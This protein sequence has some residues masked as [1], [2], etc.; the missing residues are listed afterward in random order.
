MNTKSIIGFVLSGLGLLGLLAWSFPQVK[1]LIPLP[2]IATDT[3]LLTA[4]TVL[5]L[6]GVFLLYKEKSLSGKTKEVPI[7]HGKEVVGFRKIKK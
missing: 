2:D 3:I 5:I 6:A 4:S 1:S 7:Y